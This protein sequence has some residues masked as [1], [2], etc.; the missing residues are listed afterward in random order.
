MNEK[1]YVEKKCSKCVER[2]NTKD[3]CN[4]VKTMDGN[5]RCPNENIIELNEYIKT[6]TGEIRRIVSIA[7]EELQ[8]FN[9]DKKCLLPIYTDN[10]SKLELLNS[11]G[12]DQI[13]KHSKEITDII[14]EGDFI[15]YSIT[16]EIIKVGIVKK[17]MNRDNTYYL[18]VEGYKLKQLK[19]RK[20]ITKK[21]LEK[22]GYELNE[23]V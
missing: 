8:V 7:D 3:L 21:E 18:G 1:E 22:V 2:E 9:M 23:G 19:I 11:I 15:V 17:Y 6:C 20:V 14:A 5:Y 13:V 12:D 4:I 10:D 16:S